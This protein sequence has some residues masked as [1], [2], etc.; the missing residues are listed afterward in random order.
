MGLMARWGVAVLSSAAA[1][2]LS[3]WVCEGIAGLDE[4]TAIG[5]ASAVLAVV[6][7]MAAWWAARERPSGGRWSRPQTVTNTV[8]GGHLR[9]VRNVTGSVSASATG[10]P[11]TVPPATGR[12]ATAPAAGPASAGSGGQLVDGLW[13][14]ENLTQVDGVDGDVTLG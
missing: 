8:V 14:G 12:P 5:V 7:A 11:G 4:G 9:Q 2:A 10:P 6:L 1:F 3:W 13:V